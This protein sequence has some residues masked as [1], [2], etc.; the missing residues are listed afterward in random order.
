LRPPA[1]RVG[2]AAAAL[3]LLL[4][5]GCGKKGPPRPPEPRGP[6]APAAVG[7]RQTGRVAEICFGVPKVRGERP[8]QSLARAE[9]LRLAFPPGG[10]VTRDPQ[11]F[12][13]RGEEVAALEGDGLRPGERVC[14]EDSG[15][16]ALEG[17]PGGW[18]LRY[19]VRIRDRRG[20]PSPL[21]AA[22]DL[23]AVSPPSA[24]RDLRGEATADGVL[25]RWSAPAGEG[26]RIYRVYRAPHGE[27]IP[28]RP[29]DDRAIDR[30]EW[31][32]E[33]AVHG[34][35]YRYV[36]RTA[37]GEG[38]PFRESDSSADI[39]VLAADRFPPAAP[40]GLVA[41]QEGGAVRLFWDPN[42]ERDLA[43][44]R[45]YRRLGAGEWSPVAADVLTAPLHLDRGVAVGERW[46]YRVT[47]VDR[48]EPPNESLPS[49]T[50]TIEVVADPV[51]P[52]SPP[53]PEGG[54][55]ER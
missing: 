12:R 22:T 37:S 44:Y 30:T 15:L 48:A 55:S 47:A 31:L 2:L 29:L 35:T 49:E 11:T 5:A 34:T 23:P 8:S 19:A 51:A 32:D 10:V 26:N 3:A 54:G 36:V 43:G 52:G 20:R 7:V 39:V 28:E 42:E 21:V 18:T 25:L 50:V 4:A 38:T 17:G 27:P 33:G 41:V 45:L 24:P 16:S 6:E 14:V 1:V 53:A 46:A 40:G 13:L 9:I